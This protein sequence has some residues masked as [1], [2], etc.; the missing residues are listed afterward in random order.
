M[1]SSG[2]GVFE[3]QWYPL[4][5]VAL[6]VMRR[7]VSKSLSSTVCPFLTHESRIVSVMRCCASI[8]VSG[9]VLHA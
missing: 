3:G 4:L 8:S 2:G 9:V 1:G 5:S 6:Y 7:A